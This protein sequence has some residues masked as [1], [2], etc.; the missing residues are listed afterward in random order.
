MF[1]LDLSLQARAAKAKPDR[2]DYIIK[3]YCTVKETNNK[4]R[5]QTT[6]WEK[7]FANDIS[8]CNI[9]NR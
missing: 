7:V 5:K 1:L 2:W 9:Q 6:E 4:L 3:G 8:A